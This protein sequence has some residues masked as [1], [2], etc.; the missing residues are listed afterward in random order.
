[1]SLS[2]FRRDQRRDVLISIN[3]NV[4]EELLLETAGADLM[5]GIGERNEDAISGP[6]V[7]KYSQSTGPSTAT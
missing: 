2:S 6:R 5:L 4:Q 3:P 7:V 1:M